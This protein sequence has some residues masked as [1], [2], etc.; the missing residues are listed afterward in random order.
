MRRG[1]GVYK[2]RSWESHGY[3]YHS[4]GVPRDVASRY[5]DDELFLCERQRDGSILFT[6]LSERR[7]KQDFE[8]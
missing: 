8:N 4:L 7:A 2:L 5:D 3:R 1:R 6:P